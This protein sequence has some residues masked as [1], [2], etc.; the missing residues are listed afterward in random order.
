MTSTETWFECS[1][2]SKECVGELIGIGT[3]DSRGVEMKHCIRAAL[4]PYHFNIATFVV[5][6]SLIISQISVGEPT[7]NRMHSRAT[8]SPILDVWW[9]LLTRVGWF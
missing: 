9:Y 8:L 5:V 6:F 7:C 2:I 1:R 4:W 3:Y